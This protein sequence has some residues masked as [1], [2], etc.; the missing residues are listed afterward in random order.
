MKAI[1]VSIMALTMATSATKADVFYTYTIVDGALVNRAQGVL[2]DILSGT[3]T[4]NGTMHGWVNVDFDFAK[5]GHLFSTAPQ[6]FVLQSPVGPATMQLDFFSDDGMAAFR[7]Q[8]SAHVDFVG[9][10]FVATNPLFL[11]QSVGFGEFDGDPRVRSGAFSL[12]STS[13][14]APTQVPGPIA[15]GGL[16]GL[17]LASGGLLALGCWRRRR[18]A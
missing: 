16:P 9:G 7:P 5:L 18:H 11:G 10:V 12:I 2:L 15:G 4:V 13:D 17:L 1:I 3:F 14:H 8:L 6:E